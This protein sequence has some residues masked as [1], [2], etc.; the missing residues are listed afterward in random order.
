VEA[1]SLCN[2]PL[3]CTVRKVGAGVLQPSWG[4]DSAP[5][6][7]TAGHAWTKRLQSPIFPGLGSCASSGRPL[8]A[9][10]ACSRRLASSEA[11]VTEPPC[12]GPQRLCRGASP[13]SQPPEPGF[14]DTRVRP[15]EKGPPASITSAPAATC[16]RARRR[17]PCSWNAPGTTRA[18]ATARRA[19]SSPVTASPAPAASVTARPVSSASLQCGRRN[20]WAGQSQRAWGGGGGPPP[21]SDRSHNT[22]HLPCSCRRRGPPCPQRVAVMS[23]NHSSWSCWCP[24]PGGARVT[25]AFQMQEE[26]PLGSQSGRAALPLD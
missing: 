2:L 12:P 4:T 23:R 6:A 13:R 16:H 7:P 14:G 11:R 22:P 19:S 10:A 9:G 1:K 3:G 5:G 24:R 18:W 21:T 26:P 15:P 17:R 20:L 25:D 8:E